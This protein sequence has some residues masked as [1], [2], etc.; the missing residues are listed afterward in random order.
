MSSDRNRAP[1]SRS[2][3]RTVPVLPVS[4]RAE[5]MTPT[6]SSSRQAE[7]SSMRARARPPRSAAAP[8]GCWCR[9]RAATGRA[10]GRRAPDAVV[11]G[12]SEVRA[13]PAE[14]LLVAERRRGPRTASR[15]PAR[16]GLPRPTSPTRTSMSRSVPE[17]GLG[18]KY[19]SSGRG[20]WR[21]IVTMPARS[22]SGTAGSRCAWPPGEPAAC[23]P[24]S[25]PAASHR[26]SPARAVGGAATAC[27][28]RCWA[29][30]WT[31]RCWARAPALP[32]RRVVTR[33][34]R[35]R[36]VSGS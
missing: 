4:V 15:G 14:V 24:P 32:V 9:R 11:R 30:I 28:S 12:R 5:S 17:R 6:P 13:E 23:S 36:S 21:P 2:S 19:S 1:C 7:C 3:R 25:S 8:R 33:T 29:R 20:T 22:G 18:R 26:T 35:C 27:G 16:R 34:V 31:V 10:A